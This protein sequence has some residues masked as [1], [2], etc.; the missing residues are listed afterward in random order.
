[1][2]GYTG[3]WRRRPS[4]GVVTARHGEVEAGDDAGDHQ[5]RLRRHA[6]AVALLQPVQEDLVELGLLHA[7]AED[8]VL[9][10]LAQ[11]ADDGFRRAE[12]HVRHPERQ[13]VGRILVPLVALGPAAVDDVVEV[14]DSWLSPGAALLTGPHVARPRPPG[15][16]AVPTFTVT[17]E[18]RRSV[19]PSCRPRRARR[20]P[21]RRRCTSS[22]RRSV[23]SGAASRWRWC[24]PCASRSCRTGGRWRSTRRWD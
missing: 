1:M 8:A 14:V 7:V 21:G 24:R 23:P 22:R 9:D 2:G 16:G 18:R 20:R 3:V 13:H 10:A 17:S 4:P 6:P 19:W 12:V 11:R 5:E 15:S